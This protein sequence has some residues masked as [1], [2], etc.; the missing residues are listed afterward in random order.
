MLNSNY[1]C[2]VDGHEIYRNRSLDQNNRKTRTI[3]TKPH[4]VVFSLLIGHLLPSIHSL[5]TK[6]WTEVSVSVLFLLLANISKSSSRNQTWIKFK[7]IRPRKK[8]HSNRRKFS[9]ELIWMRPKVYP[10]FRFMDNQK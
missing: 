4:L 3:S 5:N 1:L 2:T 7:G 8:I 10:F 9:R 6:I